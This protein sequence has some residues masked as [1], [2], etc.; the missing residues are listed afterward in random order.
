MIV[1]YCALGE[2]ATR[3]RYSNGLLIRTSAREGRPIRVLRLEI[4]K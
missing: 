1:L 4:N 2:I 3:R